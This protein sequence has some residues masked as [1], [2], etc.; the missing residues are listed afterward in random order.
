MNPIESK[1]A[2][3]SIDGTSTGTEQ[4]ALR[5]T[6]NESDPKHHANR[7]PPAKGQDIMAKDGN[8]T[9]GAESLPVIGLP[10]TSRAFGLVKKLVS[11]GPYSRWVS[12]GQSV[13]FAWAEV[14]GIFF[15][16]HIQSTIYYIQ[17]IYES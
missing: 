2:R 17:V 14:W 13:P 11:Y 6:E 9:S 4:R 5:R 1:K 16:L 3:K 15:P 10:L 8:A 12:V 7:D